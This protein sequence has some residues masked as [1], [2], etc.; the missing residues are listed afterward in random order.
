MEIQVLTFAEAKQP[1][2][3]EKKG[4]GYMQ[5]GQNNDYPQYLLDLFNKSA[6][7]NAIIRGKV[8][9]IVGNGWAGEQAIVQKVNRE[10]TLNDLTKKVALDLEL[11]GGAYIQVIWSV[12]GGQ[13]AELWHC[14][15][16]K[17]R[18]NKDNTQFWYKEDWKA[19]RNQEKAEIYNAFNPANP[20]GVQILY[21]KEYRPGMNVYS[22]PGYFGALNY[23]ESDVEVS[24]H[25]LGNAQTGFS[26]SKL[27]TL[28]NGEPSPEEKRLV[29]RQFDNMYTGADG[30]KY[31]L[32]FV[33]DLTRKPIVDDLGASDLT[34]E[35]FGRV[36]ELIQTNIFSGHQITSPDLFGIAVP[37][38]LGNRQQLRDSYEIFN[39][40]YVRYKQM[41]LEGVFN[42]L[43]KYAGLEVELK[44][45]PTDPI[46]IEFTENVLIQNMTKDE[47][48]EM[49]NLPP[50]EVDASNEAQRVI[51]GISNL[52]P[53][54]ANKVLESM[55]QNEIRALVG[56]SPMTD[57]NGMPIV[58][59][60]P[61][62]SETS[63]NEHIKGLKGRE[64]QN[65]QR[66]IRDFNKGKITREQASSMLKGGYA[67]TDEEIFTWLGAEEE[68]FSEQDFQVF[69]EFGEDRSGYE[70]FK[71]KTRF[72]DDVDFQMFA[73][74]T[75]LQSN[76]LDLIVKDKRITPEVIADTLKEDLGAVKRVIDILIEKG[77]IKTSEVKQGK[78]ID[79]NVIIER[80]LTAPISKIV[81]AIKPQTTEIL[82]RYSYE[83]KAGFN[84]NDLDT[85][86]PFCKYLVTA[87]KF[88]SRSEIESMSARL[89]YSVWDR[90]GG[91]YTKPGTNTHSPSCR[92]EW[93]SNIVKRK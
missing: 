44:I 10:E 72:S 85:S 43:G 60:Q 46:G 36:D 41:Q 15:Y 68:Q 69:F 87:N 29:S 73:D 51:D 4:E 1:E 86:R 9:Y 16:T 21:V 11:F 70:V 64:W 82:I 84:D 83:W 50:L 31:L 52:S 25:V 34:K 20:Q 81:E 93:K 23:I 22:L 18:T 91:W 14:D 59:E 66:I 63:V 39:N 42:M 53:L 24:K 77:F 6:K 54:V 3:K 28:P 40:T 92:H 33:N 35:D 79:S 17:I 90:R 37:G 26:A 47:I 65:M 56:L 55:K 80:E 58:T 61:M 12:M 7:H 75:Q 76:I 74:V 19:T 8:N 49:L 89:G 38:Q 45:I 78:G 30:K 71:S 57:N 27:I 13:V 2:Y 32:A 67:L 48:R 62:A 5:Y 88:Y